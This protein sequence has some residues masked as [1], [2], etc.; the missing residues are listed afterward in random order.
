[1][2]DSDPNRNNS[3]TSMSTLDIIRRYGDDKD[4]IGVVRGC[5]SL[6]LRH[7]GIQISVL[8]GFINRRFRRSKEN[9]DVYNQLVIDYSSAVNRYI[10][11]QELHLEADRLTNQEST[12]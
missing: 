4:V 12:S 9:D 1:M 10:D 8:A 11:L 7:A 2:R 3:S 6:R 5:M